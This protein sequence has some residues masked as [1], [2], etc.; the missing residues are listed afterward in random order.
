MSLRADVGL[1]TLSILFLGCSTDVGTPELV[2]TEAETIV[3][4]KTD[5]KHAAVMLLDVLTLD[6]GERFC[7]ATLYE[8]RTLVTAAHCLEDA[9]LVL[10]YFGNDFF[11]DFEQLFE[12]PAN[13]IDF[14]LAEHWEAHPK[15]NPA[16]LNADIAIVRLDRDVPMRPIPL[17]N[18]NIGKPYE[19]DRMT[20]VGYGAAG[21]DEEGFPV[22]A[23]V[24]RRGTMVYRGNPPAKPLPPNSHPGLHDKK[25]RD[26]LMHL[27]GAA[28][29]SNAC[30]GDSG[31]PVLVTIKGEEQ[32]AGVISWGDDDCNAYTYAVRVHDFHPFLHKPAKGP[33]AH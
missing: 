17:A 19:G 7:S 27:D 26:Q 25:I 21:L 29:S 18:R 14:R 3:R 8:A 23:L 2:D 30:A 13:W 16:T 24:K 5:D 4:G 6:G 32:I 11:G 9:G 12:E 20:V 28:P 10:A 1:L 22:D 31:G 33:K 15:W